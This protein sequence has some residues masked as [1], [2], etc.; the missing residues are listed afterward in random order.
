MVSAVPGNWCSPDQSTPILLVS[1][2]YRFLVLRIFLSGGQVGRSY[3]RHPGH[4]YHRSRRGRP[5]K[6]QY[7]VVY[8]Y[9]FHSETHIKLINKSINAGLVAGQVFGR[10]HISRGPGLKL[11]KPC[12]LDRMSDPWYARCCY[13]K[14]PGGSM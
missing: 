8:I 11:S 7:D 10:S 9:G 3:L 4:A 14:E 6:I 13:T 5:R 1:S 2:A 12:E